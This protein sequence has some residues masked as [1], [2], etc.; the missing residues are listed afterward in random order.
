MID[1]SRGTLHVLKRGLVD[2]GFD[3]E[4]NRKPQYHYLLRGVAWL[5]DKAYHSRQPNPG[6]GIG[7]RTFSRKL[8]P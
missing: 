7:L 4:S 8:V 3:A 5:G 6:T 2:K 1:D